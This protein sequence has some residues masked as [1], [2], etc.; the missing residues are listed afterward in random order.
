MP[1]W[2]LIIGRRKES[3]GRS[4][5]VPGGA[6]RLGTIALTLA[7]AGA[8]TALVLPSDTSWHHADFGRFEHF[9][10]HDR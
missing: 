8:T 5:R 6:A 7:V 1:A 2:L 4:P 3:P 10:E 9:H